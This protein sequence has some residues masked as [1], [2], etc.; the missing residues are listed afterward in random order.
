MVAFLVYNAH[1]REAY[2]TGDSRPT[3]LLPFTLLYE[4]DL[5][6]NEYHPPSAGIGV[7]IRMVDGRML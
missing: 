2:P 5:D 1:G 4:G 6:L 3:A 7:P